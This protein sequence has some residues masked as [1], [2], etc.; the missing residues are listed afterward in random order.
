MLHVIGI[1]DTEK[2]DSIV[3]SFNNYDI[4]YLSGY[5]ASLQDHG[6]GEPLLIYYEDS[7]IRAINVVMKRD[8]AQDKNFSG[9]LPPK[10]YYDFST[11][12]GY[13]GFIME[14]DCSSNNIT[15]LEKEYTTFCK[16]KNIVCEFVR[17]HPVLNNAQPLNKIYDIST[18]GKTIA[19]ELSSRESVWNGLSSK[20]RNVIRKA[21]KNEVKVYWGISQQLI[22]EFISLYNSTMDRD[23]ATEYYYF[24]RK[25]YNYFI[26]ELKYNSLFF[27]AVYDGKII[28]MSLILYSNQ[29]IHYHLS[30]SDKEY[31]SL[32]P[33]NL[34]LLEVANW[35]V[36]NGFS[37]LHLGGG[38]G[39]KEDNLFKFKQAFNKQSNTEFSIGKKIFNNEL[40][41]ELISLRIKNNSFIENGSFFPEYRA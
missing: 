22:D 3:K 2:W 37:I 30:G 17:L 41:Q 10:T 14:G 6:D 15:S 18:M 11:P 35:G 1:D 25:Y 7:N 12:Y 33:T 5:V 4:Y 38:L 24:N 40:Y 34:L 8:I 23:N 27:Y 36:E 28:S 31:Q 19:L 29:N 21:I 20:N 9:I 16:E 13:G 26:E 32:A 39:G